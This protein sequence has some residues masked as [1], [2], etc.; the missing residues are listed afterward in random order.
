MKIDYT[1]VSFEN[2]KLSPR[3]ATKIR[4]YFGNKY[5]E[6]E[7]MH[8]HK[9]NGFIFK[10]PKVQYKVIDDKPVVCGINEGA[11][12]AAK[13]GLV[14]DE[15]LID[16]ELIDVSQKEIIKKTVEF[17]IAEDYIEYKFLTPWIALNQKNINIYKELNNIKKEEFLNKILI[18]NILSMS[19]GLEYTVEDKIYVWLNV[20]ESDIKLKGISM[21]GFTGS[22]KTN[23]KIPNYLGIGKSVSRGFGTVRNLD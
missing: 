3:Y 19:K 20:K 6:I 11:K 9:D 17:G 12:L 14:D 7:M 22:F 10:Y 15:I 8:N 5:K 1:L 13:L 2:L 18:G 21:K 16:N 23:F 4:G